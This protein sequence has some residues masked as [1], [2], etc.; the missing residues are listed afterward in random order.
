VIERGDHFAGARWKPLSGRVMFAAVHESGFGTQCE[1]ICAAG[2]GPQV[3]AKRSQRCCG[4]R[5]TGS[6]AHDPV[7]TRQDQF[8]L[9]CPRP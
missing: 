1:L 5:D 4:S 3:G 8:N 6:T 9:P 7:Q 2:V